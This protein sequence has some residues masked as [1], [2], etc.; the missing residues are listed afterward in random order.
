L[1]ASAVAAPTWSYSTS[2]SQP[3]R[4]SRRIGVGVVAHVALGID[5]V[6][7]ALQRREEVLAAK[8]AVG[9]DAQAELLLEADD[10]VDG[11]VLERPQI[12][13]LDPCGAR[14]EEVVGAQEAAERIRSRNIA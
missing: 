5:P 9:H 4:S 2:A 3:I 6:D 12:R 11:P 7:D 8:L 14:V 13:S 10:L 1:T